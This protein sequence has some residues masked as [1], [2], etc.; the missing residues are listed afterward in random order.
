MVRPKEIG[1]WRHSNQLGG[2]GNRTFI[3]FSFYRAHFNA[4]LRKF[5]PLRNGLAPLL[6]HPHTDM[7]WKTWA[8]IRI[9]KEL[10]LGV[11]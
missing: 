2:V 10:Y 8:V 4:G 7:I 3:D 11:G 9:Q 6:F 1:Y 5:H